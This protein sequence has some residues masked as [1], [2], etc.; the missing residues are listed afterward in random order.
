MA[1]TIL[2]DLKNPMTTIA[3]F[4]QLMGLRELPRADIVKYTEMI[5]QQVSQ[6]NALAQEL[7][8]FA[9]GSS[10]LNLRTATYPRCFKSVL[11]SIE[12][13]LAQQKM[14]FEVDIQGE[15]TLELDVERFARVFENLS[16]N[17]ME[18]MEP[19]GV[20][21][22]SS[23][24]E[25]DHLKIELA[26]TGHGMDADIVNKVFEEFFSHHK[27]GGTG[28]GLAIV[29]SIVRDHHGEISVRSEVDVGTTFTIILPL[30]QI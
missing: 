5:S 23:R 1:S 28:L 27:H 22:F 9:R 10:S 18:A 12:F 6:F 16:K 14:K 29:K 21:S 3:G 4:A 19:G 11:N 20:F 24:V 25:R 13:N 17:A 15:A 7:L 26:D 8:T 2:H 30:K